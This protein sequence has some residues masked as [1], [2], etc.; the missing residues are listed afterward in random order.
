MPNIGN[1]SRILEKYFRTSFR[2]LKWVKFQRN[3]K[4]EVYHL[5]NFRI[6]PDS[7]RECLLTDLDLLK[8]LKYVRWCFRCWLI[9]DQIRGSWCLY[10]RC[11]LKFYQF[12]PSKFLIYKF[13]KFSVDKCKNIL[14]TVIERTIFPT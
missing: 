2:T 13:L 4:F 8:R 14:N 10:N 7:Y 9:L 11:F 6:L 12:K 5:T 3:R 1:F